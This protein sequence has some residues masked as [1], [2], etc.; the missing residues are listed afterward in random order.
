MDQDT[1]DEDVEA[2][3]SEN[4]FIG[5]LA[6]AATNEDLQEAFAPFGEI[7]EAV[8]IR[9]PDT[10]RSKGYGFVRYTNVDDAAKALAEMDGKE[11]A[12][13]PIK[14]SFARARKEREEHDAE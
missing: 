2:E 12:G 6:W 9:Y 11:I 7:V 14:V 3:P 8:V 4:L 13:R 5:S 1:R 10:G